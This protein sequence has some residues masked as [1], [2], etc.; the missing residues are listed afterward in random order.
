MSVDI[1]NFTCSSWILLLNL[2]I[3]IFSFCCY[4]KYS[5]FATKLLMLNLFSR[6]WFSKVYDLSSMKTHSLIFLSS[7]AVRTFKTMPINNFKKVCLWSSGIHQIYFYIFQIRKN[8][9]S[10]D[11]KIDSVKYMILFYSC[12]I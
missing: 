1:S 3:N 5:D 7:G 4:Y 8:I 6:T 10:W 2:F 11:L 9:C 12:F